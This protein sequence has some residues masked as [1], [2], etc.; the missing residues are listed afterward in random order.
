[1]PATSKET[2]PT[3]FAAIGSTVDGSDITPD[4]KALKHAQAHGAALLDTLNPAPAAPEVGPVG[5]SDSPEPAADYD[6]VP[7]PTPGPR[8]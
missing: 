1:M 4:G 8:A 6:N 2:E 7:T 5:P 3:A